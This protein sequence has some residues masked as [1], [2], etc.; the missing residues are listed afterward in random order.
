MVVVVVVVVVV[1]VVVTFPPVAAVAWVLFG[2]VHGQERRRTFTALIND[3][4]IPGA[5]RASAPDQC[6]FK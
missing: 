3:D 2:Q 1:A 5:G 4:G 6:P